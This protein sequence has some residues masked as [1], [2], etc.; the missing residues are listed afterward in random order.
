MLEVRGDEVL[1]VRDLDDLAEYI[2]LEPGE[3]AELRDEREEH[4][5]L[6]HREAQG[7]DVGRRMADKA[8]VN[9]FSDAHNSR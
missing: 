1:R 8:L 2:E 5:E 4:V 3:G 7:L 6:V 9:S